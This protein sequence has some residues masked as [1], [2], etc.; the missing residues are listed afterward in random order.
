MA[1]KTELAKKEEAA[2]ALYDEYGGETG[3]EKTNS[4]DYAIPFIKLLQKMSPEVDEDHGSY[5]EGAK[6]GMYLDTATQELMDELDFVP[7]H[8]HR[9]IVEWAGDEPGSGF[10]GQ[11]EPGYEDKFPRHEKNGR[12]TGNWVTPEGHILQDT[13]Y[14]FGVR[15][16]DEGNSNLGVISMKSTQI[17]KA[18]QWMN[19]LQSLKFKN[20][21]GDSA[22][23]PIFAHKWHFSSVVENRDEQSWRGY[24]VE[25]VEKNTD[26][27]FVNSLVEARTM[28]KG[29][30]KDLKEPGAGDSSADA[31]AEPGE[32]EE[33]PF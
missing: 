14:F 1:T 33:L 20:A 5:I 24:K 7:C 18:R 23:Y 32:K 31:Q 11:H 15:V 19:R 4:D 21:K 26:P 28:F 2:V 8:Y 16:D 9:A 3:F 12:E 30:A 6:P 10:V 25:L 13:R 22:I 29:A 17:K 27:K